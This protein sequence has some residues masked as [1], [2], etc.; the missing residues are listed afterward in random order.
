MSEGE[1]LVWPGAWPPQSE[2]M[3]PVAPA[4]TRGTRARPSSAT[5]AAATVSAFT[6]ASQRVGG[7][8]EEGEEGKVKR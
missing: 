2:D 3:W 8:E 6:Q 1:L 7:G 4:Q 5:Q